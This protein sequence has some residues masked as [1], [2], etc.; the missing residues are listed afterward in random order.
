MLT[1]SSQQVSKITA[2]WLRDQSAKAVRV[3]D[4]HSPRDGPDATRH[5][6]AIR[7]LPSM[8]PSHGPPRPHRRLTGLTPLALWLACLL[9]VRNQRILTAWDTRQASNARRAAA[10]LP[11]ATRRRRRKT[12]ATLAAPP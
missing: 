8:P 3:Q 7:C 10:G 4:G 2:R 1:S 5:C 12:L 9:A 11:P 6:A